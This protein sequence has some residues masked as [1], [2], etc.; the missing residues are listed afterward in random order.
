MTSVISDKI[1]ILTQD[2]LNKACEIKY[3]KVSISLDIH[4]G[5]ITDIINTTSISVKDYL[6]DSFIPAEIN[7]TEKEKELEVLLSQ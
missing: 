5:R 3:G 1:L 6:K 2:L 4:N 7:S